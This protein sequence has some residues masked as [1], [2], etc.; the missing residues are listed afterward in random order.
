MFPEAS[1]NIDHQAHSL[2]SLKAGET[3]HVVS[4]NAKQN[5]PDTAPDELVPCGDVSEAWRRDGAS[6]IQGFSF[7]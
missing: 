6:P 2:L 4:E 5:T 7:N 3:D 1:A